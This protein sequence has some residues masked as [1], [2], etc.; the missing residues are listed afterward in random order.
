MHSIIIYGGTFDPVHNGHLKT[1]ANL[2]RRFH[3]DQFIFLPCKDPVLKQKATATPAQRVEM[4]KLALTSLPEHFAID[5]SEIERDSPSYMVITLADFRR[6]LGTDISITLL[7]GMD[8]FI[9]LPNWHDWRRILTLANILIIKRAGI[10]N[11]R[12]PTV[13]EELL[14]IHETHDEKAILNNSHGFIYSCDAGSF[15]ISS[16]KLRK[17]LAERQNLKSYIPKPVLQYI[18]EN[19][20]YINN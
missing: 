10:E 7:M 1:A 17:G 18:K 19:Q 2:Q 8:T 6:R 20:I 15:D 4:L 13:L 3:F 12:L 14:K 5:L 16:T 11:V 9:Q